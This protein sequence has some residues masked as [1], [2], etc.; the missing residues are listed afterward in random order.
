MKTQT[1]VFWTTKEFEISDLDFDEDIN[2]SL[3]KTM[4][5]VMFFKGCGV[6]HCIKVK[7]TVEEVK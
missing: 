1:R 7:I 3:F 6:G 5:Q 4:G 2:S